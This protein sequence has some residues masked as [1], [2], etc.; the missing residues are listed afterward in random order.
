ML[1]RKTWKI[2]LLGVLALGVAVI[3]IG[4]FSPAGRY[5]MKLPPMPM[6]GGPAKTADQLHIY[7]R[8][9][10]GKVTVVSG[11]EAV[12]FGTYQRTANGWLMEFGRA[13][14]GTVITGKVEANWFGL[15]IT[16]IGSAHTEVWP[17]CIH[18][19]K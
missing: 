2:G 18:F 9:S 7:C 10:G 4:P 6:M 5:E 1:P 8:L 13:D 17:R 11:K 15:K 19:W 3:F 12:N 14:G 16:S